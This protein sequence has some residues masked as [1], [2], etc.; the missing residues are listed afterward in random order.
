MLAEKH[1]PL[2]LT[3]VCCI[4]TR[5]LTVGSYIAFFGTYSLDLRAVL[6]MRAHSR[7]KREKKNE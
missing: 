7:N 6:K 3:W 5:Y 1:Y 2:L 4:R